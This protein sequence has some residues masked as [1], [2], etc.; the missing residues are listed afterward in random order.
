MADRA[1]VPRPPLRSL[2]PFL[3]LPSRRSRAARSTT[4]HRPYPRSIHERESAG[5]TD[6]Y[7][8]SHGSTS[9]GLSR[10]RG[11][12]EGEKKG[13]KTNGSGR[14]ETA[15]RLNDRETEATRDRSQFNIEARSLAYRTFKHIVPSFHHFLGRVNCHGGDHVAVLVVQPFGR[16]AFFSVNRHPIDRPT[17]VH[18]REGQTRPD[19]PAL[20]TIS[21]VRH[22]IYSFETTTYAGREGERGAL[23]RRWI[24]LRGLRDGSLI[25]HWII[26]LV[27][28]GSATRGGERE[29]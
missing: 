5:A 28:R 27:A 29:S 9:S 1:F 16:V 23:R 12:G 3:R 20:N 8:S 21:C 10:L 17:A 2:P 4:A 15:E 11:R 6:R 19:P 7:R 13:K 22:R 24:R 26:T 14:P 25:L 18:H